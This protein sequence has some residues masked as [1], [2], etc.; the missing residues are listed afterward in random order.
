MSHIWYVYIGCGNLGCLVH[1]S[2]TGNVISG[3][4]TLVVVIWGVWYMSV[5]QE[6]SHIWYVYIG[7]GNLGCLVH[8][9]RTGNVTYLVS[10]H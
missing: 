3:T 2:R 5:G 10:L 9:S 4:F 6:M 8:V 1:V 7:C